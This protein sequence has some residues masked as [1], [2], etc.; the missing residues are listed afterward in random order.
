MKELY[1]FLCLTAIATGIC[2]CG[3]AQHSI[4]EH[5]PQEANRAVK[6]DAKASEDSSNKN[7]LNLSL[8]ERD[9]DLSLLQQNKNE[10]ENDT[11]DYF[12]ENEDKTKKISVDAKPSF[13]APEKTGDLPE[14]EGGNVEVKMELE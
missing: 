3:K 7:D 13:I 5:D 4:S 9:L 10:I 6:E 8:P 12:A 11:R 14:L 1:Y 2:G